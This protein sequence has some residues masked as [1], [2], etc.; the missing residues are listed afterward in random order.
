MKSI[1]KI[2]F[3]LIFLGG[4]AF[5]VFKSGFFTVRKITCW[6][7]KDSCPPEIWN[8][9]TSLTFGKNLIF[10]KK[11]EISKKFLSEHYVVKNL[12]IKKVLPNKL[13]FELEKRKEVA[14]LGFELKLEEK[15]TTSSGKPVFETTKDFFLVDEEG[16]VIK[17]END[18]LLPLILLSEQLSLN[19]GQQVPQ[20]EIVEAIKFLTTLRLNLLEPKIA[21]ITSPYSLTVWLKDGEEVVFSLK[22]EIQVQVD[23]LQFILS[24]S[25]IEGKEIK[26]ID[27]RFD[28]P[29]V[30]YE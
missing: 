18:P 12:K 11:E 19:V 23:S 8:E 30:S 6:W 7:E 5:I 17:K 20:R 27:L 26:K 22:K 21:K 1:L 2:L 16:V 3:F 10:L 15:E 14:V 25:K 4:V 13:V 29:V 24:R 28:K 9:L